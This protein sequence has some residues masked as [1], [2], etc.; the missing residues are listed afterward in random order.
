MIPIKILETKK[1][2][3]KNR[4]KLRKCREKLNWKKICQKKM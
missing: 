2:M 3:I 1:N 4:Y